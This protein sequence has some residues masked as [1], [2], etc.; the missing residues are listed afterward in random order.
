[1]ATVYMQ[2]PETDRWRS[3]L[4]RAD[5]QQVLT[6]MLL[7]KTLLYEMRHYDCNLYLFHESLR[8]YTAHTLSFGLTLR[9]L[10]LIFSSA[11]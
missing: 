7:C 8:P 9:T 11:G 5:A 1:M 10:S 3:V 4:S 6:E 2:Q